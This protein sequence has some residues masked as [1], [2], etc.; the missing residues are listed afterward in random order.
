L[1]GGQWRDGVMSIGNR[2]TFDNG[3]RSIEVNLFDFNSDI[4]GAKITIRMSDF[5]RSEKKFENSAALIE[6]MN[7]DKLAAIKLLS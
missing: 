1:V 5:I 3:A 7:E 6:A 4:Y 2:P